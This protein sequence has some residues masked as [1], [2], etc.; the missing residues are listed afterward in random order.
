MFAETGCHS[1]TQAGISGTIIANCSL[2]FLGSSDPPVSAS[3]ILSLTMLPRLVSNS[4]PQAI[5]LP[6]PTKSLAL[7]PGARL[8]C[9]GT[10]SAH[11][12]LRL[13][14]S[15]NSPASASPVADVHHRARLIFVFLVE[16]GFRH[17]GQAGLELLTSRFTG[18]G[19]PKHSSS[20][21]Q[22]GV[23]WLDFSSLQPLPPGFNQFFCL[24]LPE[25]EFCPVAQASL[26]L[27]DSSSLP[28]LASQIAGIA[29]MSHCTQ[30]FIFTT[31]LEAGNRV[32]L[33]SPRLECNGT[34]S[35]HCSFHFLGFKRFSCLRLLNS[36][37]YRH[38]P[39]PLLILGFL[40]ATGYHHVG[41]TSLELLTSGDPSTSASQSGGITDRVSL[42]V[43]QAGVHWRSF[44]SLQPP[45]PR[46]KRFSCFS[47]PSDR[48][49]SSAREQGLTDDECDDL[50]ESGFR[51]WIIR[52]FCELKQHVLTQCKETKNL[53]R[54]FN[55]MLTRMD[56]LEKNISELMELKNTTQE[57]RKACTT[58]SS[59]IDQAEERISEVEDQLSEIKQE[60][61]MTE[62]RIKRNE[63]SL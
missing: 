14:G 31:V 9:S 21:A 11:C 30:T 20:V 27:L 17:V 47:V 5:L 38:V 28:A 29:G 41:Q 26:E 22:A 37:D 16:M 36:W 56:N 10:I 52:N 51:R 18:L 53:E 45:P 23:Q 15:S 62:K 60:G 39:P 40:V 58:F 8:E 2:N 6:R 12:D 25:T 59:R 61:K 54:R 49:S 48:S 33:L 57:L 34:S 24:S 3:Q 42:L 43:A 13:P 55:E 50:S 32:S 44:G 19:L 1:A 35:S 7:S 63:Q 4:W 46:F